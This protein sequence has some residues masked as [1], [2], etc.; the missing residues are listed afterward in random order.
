MSE[1]DDHSI[2]SGHQ[3][4]LLSGNYDL[5]HNYSPIHLD[6]SYGNYDSNPGIRQI[7][8]AI[9]DYNFGIVNPNLL[10]NPTYPQTWFIFHTL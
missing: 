6:K 10:V 2:I 4:T 1:D 7:I 3:Y 5:P 8:M 9:T